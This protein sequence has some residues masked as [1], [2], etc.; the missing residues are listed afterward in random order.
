MKIR[1]I[2]REW[3]K[4][5]KGKY[6]VPTEA[7]MRLAVAESHLL[8]ARGAM[9]NAKVD[10]LYLVI[11]NT[12]SAIVIAKEGGLTTRDH[13]KKIAKLFKHI[14]KK[15]KIRKIEHQHFVKFYELWNKCRYE[16]HMPRWMEL[17]EMESFAQ[18][19]LNFAMTEI[20]R[21]H[22]SDEV[23][24]HDRVHSSVRLF[25]SET[26]DE[27]VGEIHERREQ[28]ADEAGD[29]Y[30]G[31]L[32]RKLL[33]PWLYADVSMFS[34]R[35][36]VI[37]TIDSNADIK[38]ILGETVRSWDEIVNRIQWENFN[39]LAL[40]IATS[41]AIKGIEKKEAMEQATEAA[42]KHP[43]FLKFRLAMTMIFDSSHPEDTLGFWGKIIGLSIPRSVQERQHEPVRSPWEKLVEYQKLF[44]SR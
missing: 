25:F 38:K 2:G 32:A 3:P 8:L 9:F 18:H 26:I 16:L 5:Y 14:G 40:E 43:D 6:S 39:R 23:L 20:A 33:N 12:L 7:E 17:R 44:E 24:L 29:M 19:L 34:D 27:F 13:R 30:G 35:P 10:L 37:K 11:D 31:K 36:E 28:D 15:A 4:L 1:K 41:K 42:A 21:S 22:R